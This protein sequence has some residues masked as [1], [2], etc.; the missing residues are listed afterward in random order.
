ML[1]SETAHSRCNSLFPSSTLIVRNSRAFGMLPSLSSCRTNISELNGHTGQFSLKDWVVDGTFH[2]GSS[3][4]R[5]LVIIGF[6]AS[7]AQTST[8]CW[9]A[10]P[11]DGR[12]PAIG[13]TSMP[14]P[15]S[16]YADTQIGLPV[17]PRI[18][19]LHYCKQRLRAQSRGST[20]VRRLAVVPKGELCSSA[21]S[22]YLGIVKG[23]QQLVFCV[24]V[25]ELSDEEEDLSGVVHPDRYND[26][27]VPGPVGESD[28][29]FASRLVWGRRAPC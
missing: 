21:V 5:Q 2:R 13:C 17:T 12:P 22:Y 18:T 15:G 8:P 6:N 26:A 20:N 7:L 16:D 14:L 28:T 1:T 3:L 27:R 19:T 9:S 25:G 29:R 10:N 24:G 23:G 4:S 11:Q